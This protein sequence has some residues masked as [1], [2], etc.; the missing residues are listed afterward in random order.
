ME[1]NSPLHAKLLANF[2][3][4]LIGGATV[5][6]AR[7][8]PFE[9]A[10]SLILVGAVAYLGLSAVLAIH[11]LCKAVPTCFRG[12]LTSSSSSLQGRAQSGADGARATARTPLLEAKA[13]PAV[14]IQ[15]RLDMPS[16]VY[17]LTLIDPKSA[18]PIRKST[19]T[20]PIATWIREDGVV[21]PTAFCRDLAAFSSA[22]SA[23]KSD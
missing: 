21:C 9:A 7:W 14:W 18:R 3:L 19:R 1:D 12:R 11:A 16:A 10:K 20:F 8:T 6:Y 5:A 2:V 13:A 17:S 15:S 4:I 23:E 22:L